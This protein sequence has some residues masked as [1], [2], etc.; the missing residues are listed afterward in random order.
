MQRHVSHFQRV[1]AKQFSFKHPPYNKNSKILQRA[2]HK[3]QFRQ[4]MT[5]FQEIASP[6]SL[7]QTPVP[8]TPLAKPVSMKDVLAVYSKQK[9]VLTRFGQKK[10]KRP[11][12]LK[13]C[14]S[15]GTGVALE[16]SRM[17]NVY[18]VSAGILNDLLQQRIQ[19]TPKT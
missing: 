12:P 5:T 3:M 11:S 18:K 13:S 4:R 19:L 14:R 8:S 7:L 16:Q 10:E 2:S 17:K 15:K 1:V 9:A 6:L